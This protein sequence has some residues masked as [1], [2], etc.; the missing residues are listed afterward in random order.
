M[1][2]NRK[3]MISTAGSR[4]AIHWPKSELLW[5]EFTEKLKVPVRS[6]ETM[7]EYLALPKNR[8][9]ELK[10]VGGFVG[11]TFENDRRKSAY[12]QGRDLLTLDLDNISCRWNGGCP[13]AGGRARMCGSFVQHAETCRIRS[14]ASSH[15]PIGSDGFS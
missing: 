3:L 5:S 2:Y 1:Q 11:G 12:V 4:K 7:D 10:D 13:E 14:K 8:Q 6:T 9:A 15:Y